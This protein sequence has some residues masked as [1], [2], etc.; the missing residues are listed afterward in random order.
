MFCLI[1][2]KLEEDEEYQCDQS[3]AECEEGNATLPNDEEQNH[4]KKTEYTLH[5]MSFSKKKV[6]T[7]LRD[8][9]LKIEWCIFQDVQFIFHGEATVTFEGNNFRGSVLFD[10]HKYTESEI[11]YCKFFQSKKTICHEKANVEFYSNTCLGDVLFE[12]QSNACFKVSH[13]KVHKNGKICI[14]AP[15]S[16]LSFEHSPNEGSSY[17]DRLMKYLYLD[18]DSLIFDENVH[19]NMVAVVDSNK[20]IDSEVDNCVIS[21]VSVKISGTN[22]PIQLLYSKCSEFFTIILFGCVVILYFFLYIIYVR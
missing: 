4:E 7:F 16:Y 5:R 11:K 1:A 15:R 6:Y 21:D 14:P 22:R 8:V 13:C 12:G 17:C 20:K 18:D 9:D 19:N 10:H 2:T 3:D